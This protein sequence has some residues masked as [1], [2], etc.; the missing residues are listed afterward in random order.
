MTADTEGKGRGTGSAEKISNIISE[1]E[2]LAAVSS[3]LSPAT[4]Q[5]KINGHGQRP[6][7]P[8]HL[9]LLDQWHSQPRKAANCLRRYWSHRPLRSVQNGATIGRL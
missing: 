5:A 7:L 4:G 6:E 1:V 3:H 2:G 8:L 9:G